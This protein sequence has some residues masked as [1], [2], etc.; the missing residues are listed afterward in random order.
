MV[1]AKEWEASTG[2]LLAG[3][4]FLFVLDTWCHSPHQL[5]RPKSNLV[6]VKTRKVGAFLPAHT[7]GKAALLT[8]Q[9]SHAVHVQEP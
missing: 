5:Q 2:L 8:K 3:L 7:L 9:L 6:S 4:G 1:T